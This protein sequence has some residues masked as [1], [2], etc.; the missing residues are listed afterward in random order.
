MYE[1]RARDG[2]QVE[3]VEERSVGGREVQGV[4]PRV[5]D[6]GV[7]EGLVGLLAVGIRVGTVYTWCFFLGVVCLL[8]RGGVFL[9]PEFLVMSF[10]VS[11]EARG[12]DREE[13]AC[14][15]TLVWNGWERWEEE[16]E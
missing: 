6:R 14:V 13:R 5:A 3:L 9:G 16:G 8:L 2:A 10:R 7:E 15:E 11:L 12:R 1:G 4:Q